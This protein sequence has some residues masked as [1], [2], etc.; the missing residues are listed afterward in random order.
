MNKQLLLT[1]F[2]VF[3]VLFSVSAISA[4]EINVTDS[5]ATSL[6]DDTSDVSVPLEKTADSS[7]ISVSSDS[8]VDNDSS[9]VSLSSEEVLGSENSNT[10]STLTYSNDGVNGVTSLTVS[11]DD[12]YGAAGNV[13]STV[14][15]ADTIKSSDVTKYYK[16]STK[17]T[18]TFTDIEGNVLANT[19]VKIVV[20]G[21]TN[22]VKTNS[23]GVASLAVNLKP[24][25]YKVV[26]TNPSTN[27]Q[28]TTTFK[29]LSTIQSSD[30]SKVYTDGKKFTATFLKSNG[31]ALANKNV[32]FKINGRTYTVK[33][34]ANGVASLSLTSLARGTYK[35][36]SY[37]T[38][39]LTKTNTVKVVS[40]T[41]SKLTT[42]A[43]TFLKSDTKK[44]KVTLL[45]GLGYA[46]GAG[47]IIKFTING[48]TYTSKT[49]S[50]GI[51]YLTLPTLANGVYTIKYKFDGN[52]FY[53]ASSA[54]NKI[55]I[56]PSKTPTFTIKSGTTFAKGV[57]GTF[58]L[59]LTSGSVP[60]ASKVVTLTLNG[61][62]YTKTTDTNGIVSLPI[63]LAVG[64]YPVTYSYAGDSKVNAKSESSTIA[65][66]DRTAT[67]ITWSSGTSFDS[68]SQTFKVLLKDVDNKALSGKTVKLVANGK[69]YTATTSSTG[70]AT[71]SANLGAGNYT[72]TYKYEADGDIFNLPSS[73]S[74]KISVVKTEKQITA[75]YGYWVFGGDM[76]NVDLSSLASKGTTELFLN[77]YAISLYGKSAVESWIASANSLGMRVHIWM[78]TFYDG[79]WIN[80]VKSGSAN[81]AY[82]NTVINEAKTYAALK[83]VAGVHFDYLRYPGTAYKTSGGTA[84]ISQFAKLAADAIHKV[85]SNLIVSCS[86]MP[87]TT[88]NIYYYG[89]DISALSSYMDVLVPMAYKGNYG[90][91]TS[92]ISS[93]TKWFI[94]NSKGAEIWMG[95][96]GYKSDDDV[97]KLST[98]EITQDVQASITAGATGSIIFRWSL[99]NYV[100]FN[101]ITGPSSS[102]SSSSSSSTT[103]SVSVANILAA[104][105][106]LKT[107]IASSGVIPEKVT[108]GGVSYTTPQ[109]LYMMAQATV[110][111]NSGKT[112]GVSPVSASAPS[113]PSGSAT[114]QLNQ[115]GYVDVASRLVSFIA[116][117]NQAP[118]YA[119]STLGQISYDK[120]VDAFSRILAYYK[121]NSQLPN[122]V[123]IKN[124]AASSSSSSSSSSSTATPSSAT[125]TA[126]TISIKN[127]LTGASNLKTYLS[128]KGSLPNTVTAGGI[129][130]TTA[131][132]LYLMSQA[133]YQ[134]GNSNSTDVA[135]ISGV[136]SPESPS[137]DTISSEQLTKDNYITVAN[138]VAKFIK[139]NNLAPNYA[140]S[141]V[142]K[143]IYSELVD[144]FSRVLAYYNT[145][146]ALP[147]YVVV[148]YGSG[149]SSSSMSATGSGINQKNTESDV[150]K[151]LKATTNCQVGNS[152]IKSIVDS[153]TSGLTSDLD[154]AKA[155]YNYVR[156][157]V[158][159]SFY[160]DTRYG[161][162]GTLNAKTGNCV[163]QSHLVIS[164]FRTA[165]LAARYVHGTCVFTSSGSTYGHVWAQVLVDG[166]WYVADC[167]STRNSFG[168]V[169][170]WYTS[171]YSLHGIYA[172][173][174][175]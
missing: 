137:G 44:I 31:K 108:V 91:S 100:N 22:T 84:A 27:Y 150:S 17:Y 138:N 154:K 155:I 169:A 52:T 92:W 50:K 56:L 83:G 46:P 25:T 134:I 111:L 28:L 69:T 15:I 16:G 95:L 43:Y 37:N 98:S 127:I 59:A 51:A 33:T 172:S 13:S 74:Q 171:S 90:K 125:A 40:S 104:A 122:Q 88:S 68:G 114:G 77:S 42:S 174:S 12:V 6:V 9:K 148:T 129:T 26:A 11:S 8:N 19:N 23:K 112:T 157:K 131:E 159:Y 161:A 30:I 55:T 79:G 173:I 81:T 99:S 140:S 20:N 147:N 149:S 76:K 72:V 34:N 141:A 39:G 170:N 135:Y 139:T 2:L 136:S 87:E 116:S 67:S 175:F 94:Q 5:Y 121:T 57:T 62:T 47:K 96:Q 168:Y 41:T 103:G 109:F 113:S 166:Q 1:I 63:S 61:Q 38:D 167:T 53:K 132:F 14:N 86:V 54:S 115:A 48:K 165:G 133:I 71:F 3:A 162:V 21:A 152:A 117:N 97:T 75:G 107:S 105:N 145:N 45:N 106:T 85:N 29:I 158:S 70:Y 124:V 65:V 64:N 146:G 58:K 66:K 130:F 110:N 82:F 119:S 80:P 126:K 156:D 73:S 142:G 143:I 151:Y 163:D 49:N 60:L 101:S 4:S 102:S 35:I 120:L 7:E 164:M 160:Y 93:V 118:N 32:K 36:I 89:Q 78:Q 18:A 24:G 144:S 10:L 123:E 153:I 128:D